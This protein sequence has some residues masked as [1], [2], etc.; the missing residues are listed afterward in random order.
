MKW[1]AQAPANIALIKYMGKL[2][3]QQN[4]PANPSLSYTLDDLKSFVELESYPGKKDI[5]EPLD[6]PGGEAFTLDDAGQQRFIQHLQW[7]KQQFNCN[8]HF[9]IRSCNNFPTSNGLASSAA[10]FA[11]LTLCAMRAFAELLDQEE[12]P[13]AQIA[14]LSRHGSGSSCR[15]FYSPWA[16]WDEQ[17]VS[18]PDIPYFD[19]LHQVVIITHEHKKIPSSQAHQRVTTSPNFQTR[20]IRAKENLDQLMLAF[21]RQDW[22]LAYSVVWKDF[23][24]MH[25]LFETATEPFRYITAESEAVLNIMQTQWDKH[26]DGPLITMD[27][28]PNIHLLYRPDQRELMQQ[29]TQDYLFTNYD[30]L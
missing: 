4:L 13:I 29:I 24:D 14:Q 7:L 12:P 15:S 1:F 28:G 16:L 11:A 5:W 10:S 21:E 3:S 22:H 30:I 8:E 26:G 18:Q 25:R 19:L 20:P 2:D 6:M 27:A 17:E 23:M 9:T